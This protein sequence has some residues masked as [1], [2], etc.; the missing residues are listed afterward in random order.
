MFVV[1]VPLALTLW[2][3]MPLVVHAE[4]SWHRL[5]ASG[6]AHVD[7][8]AE[9]SAEQQASSGIVDQQRIDLRSKSKC[10]NSTCDP[11]FILA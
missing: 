4:S 11:C 6:H 9:G 2:G 10:P 5:F 3:R 7:G 8:G 1:A